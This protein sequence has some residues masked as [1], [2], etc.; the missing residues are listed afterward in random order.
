[1]DQ[2]KI[3]FTVGISEQEDVFRQTKR[4]IKA[5]NL[6]KRARILQ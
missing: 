2:Y 5:L 1:M 4:I 3:L 6:L